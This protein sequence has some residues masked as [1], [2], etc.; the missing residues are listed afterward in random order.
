MAR[1]HALVSLI[2]AMSRNGVIGLDGTLPWHI[3]AEL[4]RF[5]ALTM[6]HPIVMGRKTWDSIG[7]LLPGRTTIIVS[8]NSSLRVQGAHV[9]RSLEE[10]LE[11]ARPDPETFVIGGAEIFRLALPYAGRIYLTTVAI[12]CA[13][14]TFMPPIDWAQWQRMRSESHP[15]GGDIPGWVLEVY[16]RAEAA[17]PS[18]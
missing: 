9:A 1:P 7:R 17:M 13:G 18:Q 12:E 14:D 10:A 15:A 5:K 3:P 8:R 2:V 11:L 16:E 6:G 4:K